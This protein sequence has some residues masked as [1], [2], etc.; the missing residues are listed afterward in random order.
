M[1][2]W[3]PNVGS[4]QPPLFQVT[5]THHSP[6]QKKGNLSQHCHKVDNHPLP[7]ITMGADRPQQMSVYIHLL[8]CR[9]DNSWMQFQISKHLV[10]CTDY[11]W[12]APF[13]FGTACLAGQAAA[14]GL[15]LP[16]EVSWCLLLSPWGKRGNVEALHVSDV[17]REKNFLT[18]PKDHEIIVQTLFFLLNMYP[19]K[20]LRLAESETGSISF[21]IGL[22]FT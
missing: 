8:R 11:F 7:E 19:P 20:V 5:W 6:S 3:S 14:S 16:L 9:L 21:E 4:H 1:T 18:Q 12:F 17:N 13:I 15:K 10:M 22:E 2:F